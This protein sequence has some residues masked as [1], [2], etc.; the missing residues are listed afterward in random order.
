MWY[1]RPPDALR[2]ISPTTWA[3]GRVLLAWLAEGDP[4]RRPRNHDPELP[5]ELA[6]I[7]EDRIAF[8]R[9]P[10]HE[11]QSV[12]VPVLIDDHAI[13]AVG[14]CMPMF[15]YETTNRARLITGLRQAARHI[16]DAQR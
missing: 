4:R 1:P 7:R 11:I 13:A 8:R 5:R 2:D 15:R 6:R 16:G 9:S 3:T 10:D 12:A 14:L